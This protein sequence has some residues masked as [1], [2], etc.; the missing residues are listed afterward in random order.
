LYNKVKETVTTKD[1]RSEVECTDIYKKE[2]SDSR[3]I[4]L[5]ISLS[6]INKTLKDKEFKK[7]R[8]KIEKGVKKLN[9]SM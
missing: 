2:D 1:L 9:I 3:S 6:D 4:T 7:I 8:E 5:R